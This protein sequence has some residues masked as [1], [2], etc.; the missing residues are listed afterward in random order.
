MIQICCRYQVA[1]DS[2]PGGTQVHPFEDIS[3]RALSALILHI[4]L[5]CQWRVF[6][7]VKG[8]YAAG[9]PSTTTSSGVYL[10]RISADL[11]PL[12]ASYVYDGSDVNTDIFV[13]ASE[14]RKL[15][16]RGVHTRVL[17]ATILPV[18]HQVAATLSSHSSV[19]V[20]LKS[21]IG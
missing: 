13:R 3:P 17:M 8:Y 19:I 2:T 12:G 20:I 14:A 6:A 7:T 18:V 9:L 15:D 4:H 10:S 11:E 21:Q 16:Q 1:L 5:A